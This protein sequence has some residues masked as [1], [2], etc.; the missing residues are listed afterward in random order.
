MKLADLDAMIDA[1]FEYERKRLAVF[2]EEPSDPAAVYQSVDRSRLREISNAT[3]IMA[4]R[5]GEGKY[6]MAEVE[7]RGCVF[8]AM[9]G[10]E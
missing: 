7:Y 3:K 1:Q 9:V 8:Y 5:H 4:R 6:A 2:G 10:D